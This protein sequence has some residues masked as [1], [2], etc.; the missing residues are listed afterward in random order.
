MTRAL[1]ILALAAAALTAATTGQASTQAGMVAAKPAA[2]HAQPARRKRKK[3]KNLHGK[4]LAPAR[5]VKLV[6]KKTEDGNDLVGC[7]LPRGR[8]YTLAS[9]EDL[10]T[11]VYG[12]SLQQVAGAIVLVSDSYS[13]Q[14]GASSATAV[15]N[16][17]TGRHY[18][19]AADCSTLGTL[20]PC[21]ASNA[22]APAAFINKRGQAAA[23]IAKAFSDLVTIAGFDSHGVRQDFDSGPSKHLPY[24]SLMFSGGTLSWT[25]SGI[26]RSAQLAP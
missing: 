5:K 13:S 25:H 1:C 20:G 9:A 11:T 6:R 14:Y 7:V 4:D 3:C 8:V 23:A 2:K 21:N 16:L 19:I 26:A 24:S 10:F 18:V 17:R 12:Y 22:T 15:W